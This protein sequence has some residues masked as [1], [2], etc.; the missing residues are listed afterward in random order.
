M[1]GGPPF[2]PPGPPGGGGGGTAG[3]IAAAAAV[4]LVVVVGAASR[5][6]TSCLMAF[7]VWA[8]VVVSNVADPLAQASWLAAFVIVW[9]V[10]LPISQF[11]SKSLV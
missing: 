6:L 4:G 2:G 8:F 10:V 1:Q 7:V 11:I 5:K 3:L 9:V